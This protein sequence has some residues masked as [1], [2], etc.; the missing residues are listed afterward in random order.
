[1]FYI[2]MFTAGTVA[3]AINAL[4]GGGPVLTLGILSLTGIDPRIANLTSTVALS[5]GQIF[6]GNAA[7]SSLE[8]AKLDRPWL[9]FAISL[10]G[11]AAGALLLLL[12]TGTAFRA[13]VPW[14]VL[15]A[16]AIYGWSSYRPV[17]IDAKPRNATKGLPAI[18]APLAIYGGYFGGGNSFLVLAL[19]GISGHA[20]REAGAIKN[21]LIAAINLG[22]VVV[23]VF[24]GLVEWRI[25]AVLGAGG[26]FGSVIGVKMLGKIPVRAIRVLVIAFG[27]FF[28]AWMFVR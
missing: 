15:V 24:S 7:R 1:M 27:L 4:A 9:L 8:T 23:L 13:I 16:T 2:L 11:G 20:P 26:V 17:P 10:V 12:T 22:A 25:A 19:L 14:L 3:A 6:A 5:P 18:L 21:A 28:S